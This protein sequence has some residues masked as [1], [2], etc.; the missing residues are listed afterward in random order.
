MYKFKTKLLKN[1]EEF[2]CTRTE[3]LIFRIILQF[4]KLDI[5]EA[6]LESNGLI[7]SGE[8]PVDIQLVN[9]LL[10]LSN[11]TELSIAEQLITI[12]TCKIDSI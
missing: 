5:I 4:H 6:R 8:I 1:K 12:T 11:A 9:V 7:F 2:R 3:L 10:L